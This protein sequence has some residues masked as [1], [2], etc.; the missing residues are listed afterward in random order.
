M[1]YVETLG[2]LHPFD[3]RGLPSWIY[4][5]SVKDEKA[6]MNPRVS[7]LDEY[8][9]CSYCNVHGAEFDAS[10]HKPECPWAKK[11]VEWITHIEGL[12]SGL[13]ELRNEAYDKHVRA[14]DAAIKHFS[15]TL[16]LRTETLRRLTP[17]IHIDRRISERE[18]A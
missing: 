17:R 11:R 12:V 4:R 1:E 5:V 8:L 9:E 6:K 10:L 15:Q 18:D 13:V 7:P 3:A 2:V 14:L 16:E